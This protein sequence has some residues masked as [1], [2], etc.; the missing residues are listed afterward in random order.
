MRLARRLAPRRRLGAQHRRAV[1]GGGR[2]PRARER[3]SRCSS[4]SSSRGSTCAPEPTRDP[5][6]SEDGAFDVSGELRRSTRRAKR[7]RLAYEQQLRARGRPAG[8]EPMMTSDDLTGRAGDIDVVRQ[9]VEAFRDRGR[10]RLRCSR[11]AGEFTSAIAAVEGGIYRGRDGI[12]RYTRD[13]DDVF[14][15]LAQRGRALRRCSG[16]GRGGAS[17]TGSWAAARAAA[18]RCDER[19]RRSSCEQCRRWRRSCWARCTCDP[20]EALASVESRTSPPCAGTST[21]STAGDL[22][23]PGRTTP[24]SGRRAVRVAGGAGRPDL[25]RS[26]R[27]FVRRIRHWFETWEWMQRRDRGHRTRRRP[28]PVHAASARQGQGQRGRGRDPVH[29]TSTRFATDSVIARGAA[30]PTASRRSRPSTHERER[31]DRARGASRHTTAEDFDALSARWSTRRRSC[32]SGRRG[33]TR[34]STAARRASCG[35][36]RTWVE[37]WE[38]MPRGA[39][40]IRRGGRPRLR[41]HPQHRQGKGQRHRGR[42]GHVRRLHVPRRQGDAH[43]ALHRARAGARGRRTDRPQTTTGGEA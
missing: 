12:E 6:R 39:D 7:D 33:L 32:T 21:R 5:R 14:E 38:W 8:D 1:A 36:G 16:D 4:A 3:R 28:R 2:L 22:D 20:E 26:R 35:R 11:R 42:A 25:S 29:S 34:G 9:V 31:R 27:A 10:A 17:S 19:G 37:A 43:P 18:R 15:R 23:S 41:V 13:L 30:S 40:E 24:G